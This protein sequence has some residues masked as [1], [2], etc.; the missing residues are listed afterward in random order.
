MDLF[1]V[2][3]TEV[4]GKRSKGEKGELF[5]IFVVLKSVLN[6]SFAYKHFFFL[7]FFL[8]SVCTQLNNS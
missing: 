2:P 8:P 7:F 3:K 6:I 5:V 4:M 1:L